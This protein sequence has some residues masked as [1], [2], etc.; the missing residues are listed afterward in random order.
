M[1]KGS[2]G[3]DIHVRYS[4]PEDIS[5]IAAFHF[6]AG[7]EQ[8]AADLFQRA[9]QILDF[10]KNQTTFQS[11]SI[12]RDHTSPAQ[13]MRIIQSIPNSKQARFMFLHSLIEEGNLEEAA[14]QLEDFPESS[15]KELLKLRI[16]NLEEP[17]FGSPTR[18]SKVISHQS[19]DTSH[20]FNNSLVHKSAFNPFKELLRTLK[21]LSI[22]DV[23]IPSLDMMIKNHIHDEEVISLARDVYEKF[24]YYNKAITLTSILERSHPA[25]IHQKRHLARLYSLVQRWQEA[26]ATLQELIKA[27]NN[28]D[29]EDLE[30]YAE[31]ALKTDH[32]DMAISICQNIL[33][34]EPRNSKALILLGEGHM[35]KGDV[36][37]SIQHMEQV[38]EMIPE[39]PDTWLTL[40]RLWKNIGKSDSSFEI[41]SKGVLAIPNDPALLREIG[42]AHLEKKS[43]AE[44]ITYLR[45]AY[46]IDP[47]NIDGKLNFAHAEYQIGQYEH[48][49]KLLKPLMRSY[50]NNPLGARILGKIL[51]AMR[52]YQSAEPIL[53][54]A[55]DQFPED[56]ETVIEAC[57]LSMNAAENSIEPPSKEKFERMETILRKSLIVNQDDVRIRLFLTDVDRIKNSD[58]EA[59]DS[60]CKLSNE[61][62][63]DH[64][65]ISWRIPYGMG[66]TAM[67][68]GKPE[69]GLASLKEANK[70]IPGNLLVFRALSEAYLAVN[71]HGKA[72]DTAQATLRLAP[73]DI[74]NIL[75]YAKF[76]YDNNEPDEAVKALKSALQINP[77]R[78]ELKLW[79][80]KIMKAMGN[81]EESKH[82]LD[83]LITNSST[84]PQELH[85]AAYICVQ[86]NELELAVNALEKSKHYLDD[87]NPRLL[88]DLA[89]IY[90]LMDD[91]KKA[92]QVLNLDESYLR[93]NPH[94]VLLKS[95][96]LS[97]LGQYD[98]ALS[99]LNLMDKNAE[100]DLASFDSE[101]IA[102][103]QSPSPLLYTFDFSYKGYLYRLGQVYRALGDME[104]AKK[105]LSK[106]LYLAP[107]DIQVQNAVLESHWMSNELI[108]ARNIGS[109]ALSHLSNLTGTD[110]EQLDLIC[111]YAE[112]LREHGEMDDA[113]ILMDGLTEAGSKSPRYHAI[114][115]LFAANLEGFTSAK[116]YIDNAVMLMNKD[117]KS[118]HGETIQERLREVINFFC[119]SKAALSNDQHELAR[120]FNKIAFDKFS[121]QPMINWHFAKTLIL[122]AE[123]QRIADSV[124][125]VNHMTCK[126]SL[127]IDNYQLCMKLIKGLEPYYSKEELNCLEARTSIAFSG[128]LSE[129]QSS[130]A[131][132]SDPESAAALLAGC[133]DG[134]LANRILNSYPENPEVLR[135]YGIFALN[136][137]KKDGKK[138]VEKALYYD[139]SDP[140][141]HALLAMLNFKDRE[142][143]IN[144][145]ETALAFWPDEPEW[146]AL[147]AEHYSKI[148]ESENASEHISAALQHQPDNPDYWQ[149]SADIRIGNNDLSLAIEDLK[150]S[151]ALE[152]ESPDVWIKLANLNRRMGNISEAYKNYATAGKLDPGNIDFVSK[153]IEFFIDQ[154][155][156]IT[157]ENRAG[158]VLET[159][160][161]NNVR[162][163]LAQVQAKQG[164]FEQALETLAQA[165]K[166]NPESIMI[167][168]EKL[169]I[170]KDRD[171]IETVLPD[172]ITL[173]ETNPRHPEVLTTLTDWLIQMNRL[174]EAELTAQAILRNAPDHAE[175]HLMLGRLQKMKGQLDQA[176]AHFSDAIKND[177][178]LIDAFIELGK[179]YQERDDLERAIKIFQDGSKVD[180][181]DP[182]PYYYTGLALKE[183][184]D[185]PG[186]EKMLKQ[187][188]RFDPRDTRINRQLGVIK[189]LNLINNLR[190][191][192]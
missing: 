113:K 83:D 164:K 131:C 13:W 179:T 87:S 177:P 183:C 191:V 111:S 40:A 82:V 152:N 41:L 85:K 64:N 107:N 19:H 175:V 112:L 62:F 145:L 46:E 147:A 23:D 50:K 130:E 4:L 71:L 139:T 109:Q 144:S 184:K 79:L 169:K 86:L 7:D 129:N 35:L 32:I 126:E 5:R 33:K 6:Y 158:Q 34:Q 60:Y 8:K 99:T 167:R 36:V 156:Y 18:V 24:Q 45:K 61:E 65:E 132:L 53:I 77:S 51:L 155:D 134:E 104:K 143:A 80:S 151:T 136:N 1:P 162:I 89:E 58:Q 103:D 47:N 17:V 30:K 22:D 117:Q 59:F 69:I 171:N 123:Y 182:R 115:S 14:S 190:E 181:S 150:R 153:E 125:A 110:G 52:E 42:K 38:V 192:N 100:T 93:E 25:D 73:Q 154:K 166:K 31:A 49:W 84:D 91:R 120:K 137:K 66:K 81:V 135:S 97:S 116:T 168:L 9:S 165:S 94:L 11:L 186:A 141:K 108:D 37:K 180:A 74:E 96:I 10:Q 2:D 170:K 187:A 138:Q 75:W 39:E 76:K 90:S 92:L 56:A 161:N 173:A 57:E 159:D 63:D 133:K 121:N 124:R 189:A 119:L 128:S 95:D 127:S 98:L 72:Q 68:L 148:N 55:A 44:A 122:N 12:Q 15:E 101:V 20:G 27:E 146:H 140:I 149:R 28:P 67:A 102:V 118:K 142:A 157:A 114:Q 43:P 106:A 178:M 163:L 185:Y 21:N 88:M 160:N 48:A 26:F 3:I 174:K 105:T 188:K 70:K 176:V 78:S 29:H 54:Y 172:L 16:N